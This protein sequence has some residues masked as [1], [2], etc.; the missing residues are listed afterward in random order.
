MPTVELKVSKA[1][2]DKIEQTARMNG[3]SVNA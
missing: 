3:K 1:L 2:M